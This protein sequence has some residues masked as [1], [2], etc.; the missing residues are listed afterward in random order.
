MERG[1]AAAVSL[2]QS[3]QFDESAHGFAGGLALT[4]ISVPSESPSPVISVWLPSVRPVETLI[5]TGSPSF[6]VQTLES[7][8][9]GPTGRSDSAPRPQRRPPPGESCWTMVFPPSSSLP[10]FAAATGSKR[11]AEFGTVKTSS[12]RSMKIS[13]VAVM[14]GRRLRSSLLTSSSVL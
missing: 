1:V 4:M 8:F 7:I 12:L 5:S 10:S 14:P 13:A 6:K 9:S 2:G 3:A 11:R